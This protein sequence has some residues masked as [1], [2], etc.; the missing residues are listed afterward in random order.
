MSVPDPEG[1]ASITGPK[2][3]KMHIVLTT[4]PAPGKMDEVK[5]G[6]RCAFGAF[7]GPQLVQVTVAG[8]KHHQEDVP[9]C[10]SWN[11]TRSLNVGKALRGWAEDGDDLI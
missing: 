2:S 5:I 9:A 10:L 6:A 7:E 11:A 3:G 4:M 8:A 1:H